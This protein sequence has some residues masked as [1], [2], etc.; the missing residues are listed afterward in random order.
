MQQSSANE[1]SLAIIA[2]FSSPALSSEKFYNDMA[3][4]LATSGT[5]KFRTK[6][7]IRGELGSDESHF[8]ALRR[9]R[10]QI[11]GVGFQSIS[12]AVPELT[13]LNA[14]YLFN[15]WEELE[16]VYEKRVNGFINQ[17]LSENGVIGLVHYGSSWH[18][19]YGKKPISTPRSAKQKRFRALIDPSSQL[20][21]KA[22]K[23]DIFQIPGT[24]V[25]AALQTGLI[26]AG[27]TNAHVYNITGTWTE[28]PYFTQTR[29]TA[30]IISVIANRQWFQSLSL[31]QKEIVLSSHPAMRVAGKALRADAAR[32]LAQ[33][34]LKGVTVINPDTEIMRRWKKIGLSTHRRLVDAV[35]GRAQELYD[36]VQFTKNE[37]KS[38]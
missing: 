38:R 22:L 15:S 34:S 30:S 6:L 4:Y 37:Y 27:E 31:Q 16:Y 13:I 3:H 1:K 17:L 26:E 10:V 18:G 8:Y 35:G 2:A 24:D 36:L 7:L 11:T 12:T 28:A 29:H 25:V 19:I 9:G 21:V 5:K 32:M 33:N 20:F 14:P 23:A